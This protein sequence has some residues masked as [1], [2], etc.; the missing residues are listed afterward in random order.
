MGSPAEMPGEF[1]DLNEVLEMRLHLLLVHGSIAV[2]VLGTM[3]CAGA[4]PAAAQDASQ[5]SVSITYDV[6]PPEDYRLCP[7]KVAFTAVVVSKNFQPGTA[8]LSITYHWERG[9][10]QYKEHTMNVTGQGQS[11]FLRLHS[12]HSFRGHVKFVITKPFKL[13]QNTDN[14]D[15]LCHG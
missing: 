10:K 8:P 11:N 12:E 2:A 1:A 7:I 9:T 4:V 6:D 15:I 5:Y 14:L 13:V 3:L